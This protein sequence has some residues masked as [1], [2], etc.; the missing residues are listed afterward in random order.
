RVHQYRIDGLHN[1]EVYYFAVTAYDAQS[2]ESDYSDEVAVIINVPLSSTSPWEE[3][4]N[5]LLANI[6]VTPQNGPLVGWLAF[7]AFGLGGTLAFRK[8]RIS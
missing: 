1:N 7:S 6:P 4:Q 2:R 8:K 5:N 3:F